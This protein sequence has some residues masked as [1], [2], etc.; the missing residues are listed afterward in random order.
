MTQGRHLLP[1]VVRF[2]AAAPPLVGHGA[3]DGR[4]R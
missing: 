2:A 4:R 1:S 3:K